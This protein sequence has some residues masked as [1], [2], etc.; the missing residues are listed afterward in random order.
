[1][2][3]AGLTRDD[4]LRLMNEEARLASLEASLAGAVD[5]ALLDE[6]RL[7][8]GFAGL[9]T[10]ARDKRTLLS[11]AGLADAGIGDTGL[12]EGALLRWFR[13]EAGGAGPD[14]A[15]DLALALGFGTRRDLLRALAREYCF[16]QQRK[17]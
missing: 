9:L 16:R 10:R 1:M 11:E 12:D 4:F 15:A 13:D 14:N 3:D 5:K 8:G 6:L 2:R 17:A 7:E